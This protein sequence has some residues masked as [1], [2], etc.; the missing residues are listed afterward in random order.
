MTPACGGE[1]ADWRCTN[2][3]DT[4]HAWVPASSAVLSHQ[5]F[6]SAINH[7]LNHALES[8]VEER[9][10]DA[11]RLHEVAGEGGGAGGIEEDEFGEAAFFDRHRLEFHDAAGFGGVTLD[12]EIPAEDTFRNVTV[13][14]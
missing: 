3:L 7:P 9:R 12:D 10:V 1:L 11:L 2:L 5:Q 4:A 13:V 14:E 8:L 6:C